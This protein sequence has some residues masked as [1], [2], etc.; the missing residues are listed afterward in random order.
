MEV[1]DG[2]FGA[3][4]YLDF[5]GWS[6]GDDYFDALCEVHEQALGRCKVISAAKNRLTA[7][8]AKRLLRSVAHTVEKID[9][10]GNAIGAQRSQLEPC[11]ACAESFS[12][13][14][15]KHVDLGGNRMGDAC[16]QLLC[17]GL[18]QCEQLETLSLARNCLSSLETGTA[19]AAL[20]KRAPELQ[21]LDLHWNELRGP[22]ALALLA[23]VEYKRGKFYRLDLSW[24]ALG[25]PSRGTCAR[26]VCDQLGLVFQNNTTLFHLDVSF[27]HIQAQDAKELPQKLEQNH[28]LFGLHI[29]G[30]EFTID[31]LGFVQPAD[32]AYAGWHYAVLCFLL[33]VGF[34]QL[35]DGTYDGIP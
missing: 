15:V 12:L 27:N 28:T 22:G 1:E 18:A 21:A 11:R 31:D 29:V 30:N 20:V 7:Q 4:Q 17:S 26:Q 14:L 3:Y 5:S 8:S 32:G 25:K 24:N 2:R 23:S 16:G 9:L 19:I 34:V 10:R 13:S 33:T 6:L 35:A